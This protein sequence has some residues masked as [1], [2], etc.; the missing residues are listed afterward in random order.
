MESF[1]ISEEDLQV[2][3]YKVVTKAVDGSLG[4]AWVGDKA[5][6]KY[7]PGT[8]V[9]APPWLV[10]KGYHLFVFD[11]A[12]CAATFACIKP[13]VEKY[14]TVWSCEV[15]GVYSR[16]PQYLDNGSLWS[17]DINRLGGC[18]FPPGTVMVQKVKLLEELKKSEIFW[19]E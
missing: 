9:S 16:L 18:C 1:E 13:G 8:W 12:S 10:R 3:Y 5:L 6:V 17:G 2:L 19:V 7:I 4:S 11:D 15:Q 14:D